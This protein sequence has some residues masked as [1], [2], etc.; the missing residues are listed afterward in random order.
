M[1]ERILKPA[2]FKAGFLQAAQRA[3]FLFLLVEFFDE[4]NYGVQGAALPAM[5][6]DLGLDYGQ[7]GLLLSLSGLLAG[8]VEPLI[9]LFGDSRWRKSIMLGG[10]LVIA[11]SL[12]VIA[13]AQSFLPLLLASIVSYPASGAFVTLAQATLVD[14]NPERRSQMMARWSA[15]GSLGNLIG[16]L[17]MA[18]GF[19]LG[20]GWR[21][22][23]LALAVFGV[24]LVLASSRERFDSTQVHHE[25]AA[26]ELFKPAEL[27]SNLRRAFSNRQL[28]R[29]LLLLQLS[30]LLLDVFT[31]YQ[32]LYLADVMGLSNV[33]VGLVLSGLMLAGLL[34]DLLLIPLL[35]HQPGRRLVRVSA[36]AACLVY[37]AML[38]APWP[39]VKIALTLAIPF[40]TLGWYPVLLGEAFASLPERSATVM[41][42]SSLFSTL[43]NILVLLVGW[44]A[45]QAGLPTAMWLL[46]LG[47]LA[48]VIGL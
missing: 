22:A 29:W 9:L 26:D 14:Q 3:A 13:S 34:S 16:P 1:I 32:T 37:P 42:T 36:A 44:V 30:D 47:P 33:Q 21:W 20:L 43:G 4:L 40:T 19:S 7:I 41:A 18:A 8:L 31:S 15:A 38:L 27:I 2:L 11:A 5:R 12:V 35:E 25:E 17:M 6:L 10:G 23:F 28:L 48:L 45:L 46:L 39:A 24:L